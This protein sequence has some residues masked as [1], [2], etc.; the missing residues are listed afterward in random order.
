LGA[1]V[2]A[3]GGFAVVFARDPARATVGT[4]QSLQT[5][6]GLTPAKARLAA[7]LAD[8][9]SLEQFAEARRLS[10]H[11]VRTLL[12]RVMRKT[13]SNRQGELIALV[14][15]SSATLQDPTSIRS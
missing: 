13:A 3:V 15:R 11:T 14:L 8:G 2:G 10:L 4:E 5:L 12:K 7:A 6:F 9:Q 1:A